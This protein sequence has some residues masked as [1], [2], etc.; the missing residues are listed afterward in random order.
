MKRQ[1]E[2]YAEVCHLKNLISCE[3]AVMN[4]SLKIIAILGNK[5]LLVW[6]L[7]TETLKRYFDI[8]NHPAIFYKW[9][10]IDNILVVTD[11][12]MLISWN[13]EN[14]DMKYIFKLKPLFSNFDVSDILIDNRC[15]MKLSRRMLLCNVYQER[16][17]IY[18]VVTGWLIHVEN[19]SKY[20]CIIAKKVFY[21]ILTFCSAFCMYIQTNDKYGILFVMSS[22]GYLH[23]I[24]VNDSICLYEGILT[25]YKVVSPAAYKD[26]GIVCVNEKGY[27]VTAV[28][29]EEEVISCLSIVLKNKS[30]VMKFARR[31][32]LPGAE[33]VFAWKFW[34]LCD[35][36]EYYKAAELAVIIHVDSLATE[37][38]IEYLRS[39]KLGKKEPNPLCCSK[40]WAI[41]SKNMTTFWPGQRIYEPAIEC[42]S[43]KYQLNSAALIGDK[44]CTKEDYISIFQQTLFTVRQMH[45]NTTQA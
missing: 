20:G 11:K 28:V 3:F 18:S 10:D 44:N 37:K 17:E 8:R 21:L 24:D 36:G 43:E 30:A 34:E 7:Q 29:D 5:N 13:I 41:F 15:D 12:R 23:V 2:K 42:L 39:A 4:P 6:D 22:Y 1:R 45:L 25:N 35:N 38:I 16:T 27:I 40:N 14:Y 26:S 19:L 9:I 32:N 33:G 31:C